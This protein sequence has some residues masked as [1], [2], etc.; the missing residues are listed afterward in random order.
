MLW[1][2]IPAKERH[3]PGASKRAA[4]SVTNARIDFSNT[5]FGNA[6]IGGSMHFIHW[7]Y[8]N[9]FK[10][11]STIQNSKCCVCDQ[12]SECSIERWRSWFY[13][14]FFPVW[15]AA[16]GYIFT[17]KACGHSMGVE[18]SS[19]VKRYTEEQVDTGL[20]GIPLCRD[21]KEMSIE[22]PMPMN[23]KNILLLSPFLLII[24][25]G[26]IYICLAIASGIQNP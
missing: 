9:R 8:Y 2:I 24:A 1:V 22:R 5:A 26:L 10:K 4:S 14:Q 12:Y 21:L 7:G 25:V 13:L 11:L 15:L 16:K 17:W 20:F 3:M 19:A 18:D 23:L 6:E